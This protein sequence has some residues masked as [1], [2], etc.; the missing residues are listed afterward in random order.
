M[1]KKILVV[2]LAIAMFAVAAVA[3]TMAWL[4]DNAAESF[5]VTTY[6]DVSI[7]LD[8][9]DYTDN[10]MYLIPNGRYTFTPTVT[11]AA[12]DDGGE[13]EDF[14]LRMFVTVDNANDWAQL[15]TD[16]VVEA[17][18]DAG[19]TIM[20]I[21]EYVT[22][23]TGW[24]LYQAKK[25]DDKYT[26]EFRYTNTYVVAASAAITPLFT[27]F[28]LDHRLN[29]DD[30]AS[31]QGMQITFEAQA[32]QAVERETFDN[33]TSTTQWFADHAAAWAEFD[34]QIGAEYANPNGDLVSGTV[35][36]TPGATLTGGYT[37]AP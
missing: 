30:V 8:V 9:V 4:H 13:I 19:A 15:I 2:A 18:P 37:P 17:Y 21:E 20:N 10:E 28:D 36:Y 6:G 14:Y 23:G 32:M 1:K 22:L 25:V 34:K 33:A 16:E 31:L 26:Y 27:T 5:K 11:V 24:T 35:V 12:P 7:A 29:D 3:G